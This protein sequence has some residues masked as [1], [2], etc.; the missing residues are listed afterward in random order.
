MR[1][2]DEAAQ[3]RNCGC[4]RSFSNSGPIGLKPILNFAPGTSFFGRGKPFRKFQEQS[5]SIRD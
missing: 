4:E 5:R 3:A 2:I 1:L